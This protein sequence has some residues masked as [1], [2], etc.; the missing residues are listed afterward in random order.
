MATIEKKKKQKKMKE[1]YSII[2]VFVDVIKKKNSLA[3]EIFH[4]AH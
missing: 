3:K 4:K 2:I 1:L